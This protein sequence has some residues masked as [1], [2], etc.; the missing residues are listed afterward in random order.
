[1]EKKI[2]SPSRW[3]ISN[4]AADPIKANKYFS[5]YQNYLI[6]KIKNKK[7]DSI[8]IVEPVKSDEIF[9]YINSDCFNKKEMNKI[10]SKYEIIPKCQLKNKE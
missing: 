8:F 2:H 9:R 5:N 10:T 6:D 1:M 3:F 4:G 7:I